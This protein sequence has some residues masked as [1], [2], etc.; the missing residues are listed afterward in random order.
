MPITEVKQEET[1]FLKNW[2]GFQLSYTC[3][4]LT[5]EALG[6]T[7]QTLAAEAVGVVCAAVATV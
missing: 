1:L 5:S 4:A 6:F 2:G 3:V 7:D